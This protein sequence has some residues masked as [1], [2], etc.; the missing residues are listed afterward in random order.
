MHPA[1]VDIAL[2]VE[3]YDL[4]VSVKLDNG[5]SRPTTVEIVI[6][7]AGCL[8]YS[9]QN[10]TA[11]PVSARYDRAGSRVSRGHHNHRGLRLARSYMSMN[12]VT[13]DAAITEEF[14]PIHEP[15][16]SIL[17]VDDEPMLPNSSASASA[18]RSARAPI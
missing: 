13:S 7:L 3:R 11:T 5:R 1:D 16:L 17:L 4:A 10:F 18:V 15:A 8:V 14:D 9:R 6:K 2:D 12:S